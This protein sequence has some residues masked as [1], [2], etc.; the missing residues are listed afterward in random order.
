MDID[1]WQIWSALPDW[2]K[3]LI[4]TGVVAMLVSSTAVKREG[5]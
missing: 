1:P 3:F 4:L 5:E 2:L